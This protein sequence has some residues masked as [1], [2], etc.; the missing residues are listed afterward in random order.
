MA[1][2]TISTKLV[3]EGENEYRR[4]V[5]NINNSLKSMQSE[6]SLLEARYAG[7]MS[8]QQALAEKSSL[9]TKQ[10][11]LQNQKRDQ[12][13][14]GLK[15]AEEAMKRHGDAVDDCTRKIAEAEAQLEKL[16]KASAGAKESQKKLN[17]DIKQYQKEQE[18]AKAKQDA[19]AKGVEEWQRKLNLAEAD[20]IKVNNALDET[21]KS[22]SRF[23]AETL[24]KS[25]ETLSNVGNKLTMGLT[26][27]LTAAGTAAVNYASE[28]EE[29][30]NKVNEAFGSSA[31]VIQ[32]WSEGTLT[33]IGLARGTALDMAALYGD[34]ATSM[35]LGTDKAAEMSKELVNLAADLASFKNISIEQANTALKSIFTGETESL[36]FWAATA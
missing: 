20:L 22:L 24:K 14:A 31:S 26:L 30:V 35:G 33:S 25:G 17:A 7:Q 36:R 6:M 9:L 3:I 2:R 12:T 13:R 11:D 19:A 18:T 21:N 32:K 28:T 4:T 10:I 5:G 8:S 15:N 29:S 1:V 34:M 16:D 23:T 27:P